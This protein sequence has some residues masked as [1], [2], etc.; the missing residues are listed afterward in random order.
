[1]L[2]TQCKDIMRPS[3]EMGLLAGYSCW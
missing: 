1:L 2:D 3:L